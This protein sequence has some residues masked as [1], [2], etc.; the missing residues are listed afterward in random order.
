MKDL[1]PRDLAELRETFDAVD[2]DGDG[3]IEVQEF[4]RLLKVL[5]SDL[6]EEECLLAFDATD[7]DGDGSISF[8]EF[9]EWWTAE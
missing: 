1:E 8:E 7:E 2:V 9:M 4:R 5:D 6:S 3:W